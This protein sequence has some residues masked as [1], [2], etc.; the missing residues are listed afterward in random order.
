MTPQIAFDRDKTCCFTGHRSKDLPD[1]GSKDSLGMKILESLIYFEIYK[2]VS[3]GY[4]TFISGMADGIDIICAGTVYDLMKQGRKIRLV[5][6]VPYPGQRDEHL[7]VDNAYLYDILVNK[8]PTVVISDRYRQ[9]CY[10]ERNLFMVNNSSR[11][12]GVCKHKEKGSGTMQTINYARKAGLCCR[13][14]DLDKNN[15]LYAAQ[16]Y[17]QNG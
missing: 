15:Y 14:I 10:R 6:A 4:D 11:L 17:P 9:G 1:L 5:C 13:V 16:Q 7:T 12:I 2:A 8:C 3:D